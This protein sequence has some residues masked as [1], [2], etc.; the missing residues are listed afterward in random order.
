MCRAVVDSPE[1]PLGNDPTVAD[2]G[3]LH[4]TF[5]ESWS[6]RNA[7]VCSFVVAVPRANGGPA[8]ARASNRLTGCGVAWGW[9][10][11]LMSGVLPGVVRP[12]EPWIPPARNATF[13]RPPQPLGRPTL[14]IVR[15]AAQIVVQA[16]IQSTSVRPRVFNAR[17]EKRSQAT[18]TM[19]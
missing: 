5:Q 11:W 1:H 8:T 3:I 15:A 17:S 4:E 13:A 16:V 6:R 19:K 18:G 14:R 12:R 2:L 10:P 9:V 7:P